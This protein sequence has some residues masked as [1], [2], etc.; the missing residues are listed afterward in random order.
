MGRT[1]KL[2]ELMGAIKDKASQSKAAIL[3]KLNT[4]TLSS[5]SSLHLTLLRAT[6]HDPFTPPNPKSL[7]ALLSFGLS[8]RATA[9]SAVESLMDRLQTTH[10]SAV[11]LKC[12]LAVHHVIKYGSFIL[13]DQLS[14]YPA[15]GGRNYLNL[16]NFRDDSTPVAW[17]LSSWVRWYA[18]YIENL[19]LTSRLLGFFVGSNSCIVEKDKEEERVSALLNGN[20]VRETESLVSLLE[21]ICKRPESLGLG[22]NRLVIEVLGLVGEDQISAMN[23]ISVRVNEF[24]ERLNCLSFGDSVE[25]LGALKRSEDCEGRLLAVPNV[26]N[27]LVEGFWGLIREMKTKVGKEKESNNKLMATMRVE[28]ESY[29]ESAR[30]GDRVLRPSDWVRFSSGRLAVDAFHLST[31]QSCAR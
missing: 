27:D 6:T 3:C 19:L 5:S 24:D 30:F 4:N 23:E 21:G 28:K 17:E 2:R 1:S 12:L 13:Q 10:D 18:Q 31:I 9:S 15:G 29:S 16:S 11:A 25:L 20:L 22:G 8:S 7:A 26:K 14:V